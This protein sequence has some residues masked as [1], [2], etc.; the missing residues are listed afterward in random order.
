MLRRAQDH[1]A[2]RGIE[3][4]DIHNGPL[5]SALEAIRRIVV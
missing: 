5:G 2:D 4:T 3:Q 1:I